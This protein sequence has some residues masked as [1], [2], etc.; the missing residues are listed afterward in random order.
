MYGFIPIVS[1]NY[2]LT[3]HTLNEKIQVIGAITI[4]FLALIIVSKI[5]TWTIKSIIRIKK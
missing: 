2:N 3:E 4:T 5:I 1:I